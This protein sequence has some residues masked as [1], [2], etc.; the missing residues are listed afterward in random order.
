MRVVS[1]R[2]H[3]HLPYLHLI[4]WSLCPCAVSISVFCS[5]CLFHCSEA[6]L[7]IFSVYTFIICP[8][9]C[10]SFASLFSTSL[11]LPQILPSFL[12]VFLILLSVY[13]CF[14]NFWK[15]LTDQSWVT[16][17]MLRNTIICT[18]IWTA[19]IVFISLVRQM[20]FQ[21]LHME[22]LHQ[23]CGAP[24]SPDLLT[25]GSRGHL[26]LVGLWHLMLMVNLETYL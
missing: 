10:V 1:P 25:A 11:L 2:C 13:Q 9:L 6:S 5:S 26:V 20:N 15:I 21:S 8:F 17:T 22:E 23:S 18:R 16:Y 14:D 7:S 12:C 4:S 3:H 19:G 24:G